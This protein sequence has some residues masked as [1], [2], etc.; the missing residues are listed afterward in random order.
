MINCVL[1]CLFIPDRGYMVRGVV[2]SLDIWH[3]AKNMTD[4][5]FSKSGKNPVDYL[6]FISAIS[7]VL[8]YFFLFWLVRCA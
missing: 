1:G 3:A 5:S 4:T 7:G 6:L 8:L 2:C